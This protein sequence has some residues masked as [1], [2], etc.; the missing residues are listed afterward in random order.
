MRDAL[1]WR[2]AAAG[3]NDPIQPSSVPL[4]DAR[5]FL[6]GEKNPAVADVTS[7]LTPH[8]EY[9]IYQQLLVCEKDVTVISDG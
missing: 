9:Y 6:C 8:C 5:L 3:T 7:P 4:P 2:S 1:G